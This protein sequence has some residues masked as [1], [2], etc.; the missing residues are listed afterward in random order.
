MKADQLVILILRAV[1]AIFFAKFVT[2]AFDQ[3]EY[4]YDPE[5]GR[6]RFKATK[7]CLP[8]GPVPLTLEGN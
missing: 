5:T 7:N 2:E 4:D 1:V 3:I 8:T 6:Q